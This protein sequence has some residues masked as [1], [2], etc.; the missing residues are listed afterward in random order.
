MGFA[1]M[2][3]SSNEKALLRG[4][5]SDWKQYREMR[6]KASH[7]YNE[8][9]ALEVVGGI[10][11]L[12][13]RCRTLAQPASRAPCAMT[14][15]ALATTPAE[16]AIVRTILRRV[17]PQYE[18][19]AFGSRAK[20]TQK[21]YSDLDLVFVGNSPLSLAV[22]A[23]LAEAFSESDLPYK[24]DL[25]DWATTSA[26]FRKIIEQGRVVVQGAENCAQQGV[27]LPSKRGCHQSVPSLP[28]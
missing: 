21:Q 28:S 19:W 17:V 23:E 13:R 11:G 10:P 15:A 9:T 22:T 4:D 8:G 26:S 25:V 1:D 14:A 7:T 24:V 3:R 5:W 27:S 16:L 20:G 12:P 2:I 18:V 6:G